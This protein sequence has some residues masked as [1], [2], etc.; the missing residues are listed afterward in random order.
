MDVARSVGADGAA[1]VCVCMT[2]SPAPPAR[3]VGACG[4]IF[5]HRGGLAV[6]ASGTHRPHG[7]HGTN[8]RTGRTV[9]AGLRIG[10]LW[11]FWTL[12]IGWIGWI[13]WSAIER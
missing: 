10:I 8:G 13:L 4:H 7:A 9:P 2:L 3:A 1:G 6:W 11:T 12:W 5:D